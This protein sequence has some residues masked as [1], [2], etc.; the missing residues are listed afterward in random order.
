MSLCDASTA[1]DQ[2][3]LVEHLRGARFQSGADAGRWRLVACQWP[4]P[5][6]A[7][8]AAPRPGAPHEYVLHFD[9]T[10]YPQTLTAGPWD[11]EG[12]GPLPAERRPKGQHVG[13]VFR[14]DWEGGRA[15]YA[16]WDSVALNGHADWAMRFPL[17]AW[18]P[19]RDLTFYLTNVFDALHGAD[20]TGI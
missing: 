3:A 6:V 14:P 8:A 18:N 4:Y 17:Q 5:L 9:A 20:Y 7:V 13:L 16:A 11:V 15:L 12:D 10:G 2:R 1:P 19:R